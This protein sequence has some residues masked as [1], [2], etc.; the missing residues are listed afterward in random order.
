MSD[1]SR[2]LSSTQADTTTSSVGGESSSS[3]NYGSIERQG[4]GSH[5]EEG[6]MDESKT[7]LKFFEKIGFALG[8]VFNDLCAGVWFSYTLLFMQGVLQMEGLKAGALVMLGQVGDA[9]AT[10][11]VGFLTDKY[12]TKRK[13]HIFGEYQS[14]SNCRSSNRISFLGSILVFL[15][16]PLIFSTCPFCD[17]FPDWWRLGYFSIVILIFQFG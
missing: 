1:R 12:S 13:W 11:I 6:I 16:F 2:L 3:R 15:T 17:H 5:Q 9:I 10:P 7:T 4:T 14:E 8:H